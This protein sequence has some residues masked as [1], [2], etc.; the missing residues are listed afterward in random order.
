MTNKKRIRTASAPKAP[1]G[2]GTRR[3][4]AKRKP[5]DKSGLEMTD[6]LLEAHPELGFPVAATKLAKSEA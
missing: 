4:K 1:A 6:Y 5:K 2:N 3:T